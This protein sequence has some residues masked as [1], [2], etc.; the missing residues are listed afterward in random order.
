MWNE[1]EV[2]MCSRIRRNIDIY[3]HTRHTHIN[4][5]TIKGNK[6]QF[7]PTKNFLPCRMSGPLWA[8]SSTLTTPSGIFF[9]RQTRFPPK[10]AR[11]NIVAIVDQTNT[12]IPLSYIAVSTRPIVS[13]QEGFIT[14]IWT[15]KSLKT[16]SNY[17]TTHNQWGIYQHSINVIWSFIQLQLNHYFYRYICMYLIHFG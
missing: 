2:N 9:F 17:S 10:V 5:C 3:G 16:V 8:Q 15:Y 14:Y 11:L 6:L 4:T 1:K 7:C 12:W 13:T